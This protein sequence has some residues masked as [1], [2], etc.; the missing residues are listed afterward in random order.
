M[1][2]IADTHCRKTFG[3]LDEEDLKSE[4]W[5]LCLVAVPEDDFMLEPACGFGREDPSPQFR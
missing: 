2:N 3:Y 1:Q 5:S 4:I